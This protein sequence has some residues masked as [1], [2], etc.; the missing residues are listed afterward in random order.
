[1]QLT[2]ALPKRMHLTY[3]LRGWNNNLKDV[4]ISYRITL[5]FLWKQF[6]FSLVTVK[7]LS[8]TGG[9]GDFRLSNAALHFSMH[10]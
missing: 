3:N 4:L 6:T 8:R 9:F 1:M 7:T 10:E 5:T 2:N